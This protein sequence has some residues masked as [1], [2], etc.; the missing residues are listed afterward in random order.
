MYKK[1]ITVIN[2]FIFFYCQG[3]IIEGK[4]V[5]LSNPIKGS[6]VCIDHQCI[7]TDT[8]GYFKLNANCKKCN[9][10]VSYPGFINYTK[11]LNV[12]KD[13]FLKIELTPD[14]SYFAEIVIEADKPLFSKKPDAFNTEVY[15]VC[16][17]QSSSSISLFEGIQN[18]NGLRPQLN[19]NICNTGDIH[20]NGMEGPYTNVLI[21][22][23]PM[24]G[25]I[26]SVYGLMGISTDIIEKLEVNRYPGSVLYGS[27]NIGGTINIITKK[28][29]SDKLTS[30]LQYY[31][32]S[33]FDTNIDLT[34]TKKFR[35]Y[36]FINSVDVLWFDKI[37]DTNKDNI[38]DVTL[39]KRVSLFHKSTFNKTDRNTIEWMIRG[40]WEDRWGG[41]INWN[42][43]FRGSDSI[44]GESIITH[45]IESI[46]KFPIY[47][48]QKKLETNISYNFHH[49]NSYYG[50]LFFDAKQ[51]NLYYQTFLT[52][53][54]RYV[55]S[56]HGIAYKYFYYLDNTGI[57][58]NATP[59]SIWHVPA[60]YTENTFLLNTKL[61]LTSSLRYDYH[62]IHKHI[63]T[64]RVALQYEHS[65]TSI[66]FGITTGFRP[67]QLFTEDHAALTG[68]RKIV[69]SEKLKP[70]K[71]YVVFTNLFSTWINTSKFQLSTDFNAWYVYFSNRIIPDYSSPD[72]IVYSNLKGEE[73]SI[74]RGISLNIQTSYKTFFQTIFGFSLLDNFF[75][76]NQ[77]KKRLMLS[78]PWNGVWIIR[79]NITKLKIEYTGNIYGKMYLPKAG[80]LDPRPSTSPVFSIQNTQ[81]SFTIRNIDF[82]IGIK[83]LLN[84]TPDKNIPFLIARSHDPFDKKVVYDSEGN[85]ISTPENPYALTFDPTYTYASM[86]KRRLFINLLFRF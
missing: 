16:I 68:A 6:V 44:Y 12:V 35:K 5:Y 15:D 81:M 4:V 37:F 39:Q 8:S 3:Q 71:S 23:M 76:E 56:I 2:L 17:L 29:L 42:K 82:T 27:E 18:I 85:P 9:L 54:N 36:A 30:S 26:A 21:D 47:I 24:I 31:S 70:E 28:P 53:N 60:I 38:T 57:F 13:T 77:I 72:K 43:A 84:F 32:S 58:K 67:V 62:N 52:T 64:P 69:I 1:I 40:L 19:C 66:R 22:G 73:Y 20:I 61:K 86:Q 74:N 49:Q 55:K 41:Q 59:Y 65:N 33:Y 51:H 10:K 14:T 63:L 48:K 45:R 34:A 50:T 11:K 78:E 80:T 83:N 79:I 75:Y 25:G 7:T 46:L